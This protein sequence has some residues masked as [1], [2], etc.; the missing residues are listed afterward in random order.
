MS[1]TDEQVRSLIAQEAAEWFV[2]NRAGLAA[3]ER[4]SF[5]AWLRA[6]PLHVEE[7]LG[8]AAVARDLREACADSAHS[9]ESLIERART[10]RVTRAQPLWSRLAAAVSAAP[11]LR[12]QTAAVRLGAFAVVALGLFLLWD[13]MP[14]ARVSAPPEL[15]ALHFKTG[16]G[17]Q[18]THRLA[19]NSVLHLNTDSAVTV[20]YSRTQ[21]LVVLTSGEA[22]FEVAHEGER[23][24]R[25]LAG[26]AEVVDLGTKFDVRMEPDSTV[27][28]VVE[29]RVAVAPAPIPAE[30]DTSQPQSRRVVQL[31]ADQQIRVT[32]GRWPAA[33]TAVDSQ[34][35]TA[36][37]H[38]QIKFDHEPLERVASEFDRYSPKPI[39]ITTP[40]L[41]SL[42]ISGVFATDDTDAFIAFLR[43]LPGVHVEVGATRIRVSQD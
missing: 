24:F 7:Y 38:R 40:A 9:I 15:T 21:R 19:D 42:E 11:P 26:S 6:S 43:S 29:G 31:D 13:L 41:R 3:G 30:P 36:W 10:E 1:D 34:N 4:D 16:H 23:E 32:A 39:E 37:L 28:T 14:I 25:V 22:D 12:W 33:P 8:L 35:T 17:E 2:A 27:I 18:A 5:A 20:R